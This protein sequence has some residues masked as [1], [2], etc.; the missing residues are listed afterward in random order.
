LKNGFERDICFFDIIN[1][2]VQRRPHIAAIPTED[3]ARQCKNR[4]EVGTHG[5]DFNGVG[6]TFFPF[7]TIG[8]EEFG[9]LDLGF[10]KG[11]KEHGWLLFCPYLFSIF[12]L[13]LEKRAQKEK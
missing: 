5:V 2:D 6:G 7:E 4:V 1:G 10:G 11:L 12:L 8:C 3:L 13:F 9:A